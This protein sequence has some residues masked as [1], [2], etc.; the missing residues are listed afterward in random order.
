VRNERKRKA[1][2]KTERERK[3]EKE[4][5]S[6]AGEVRSPSPPRSLPGCCSPFSHVANA[7]RY[8]R[9]SSREQAGEASEANEASERAP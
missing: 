2:R 6:L 7:H 4:I 5:G 1:R 3:E 8:I 9:L